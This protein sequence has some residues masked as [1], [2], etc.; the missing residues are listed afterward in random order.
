MKETYKYRLYRNGSYFTNQEDCE[1]ITISSGGFPIEMEEVDFDQFLEKYDSI[2][3][4]KD[5]YVL[6]KQLLEKYKF[7]Y[8]TSEFISLLAAVQDHYLT[9]AE[10]DHTQTIFKDFETEDKDWNSL[11]T[12]IEAYLFRE[13]SEHDFSS[14]NFSSVKRVVNNSGRLIPL[15]NTASITNTFVVNDIYDALCK[16]WNITRE[17]FFEKKK[18]FL[19]GTNKYA[20]SQAATSIKI[21]FTQVLNNLIFPAVIQNKN[22]KNRCIGF[23][24]N[25]AQMS[26]YIKKEDLELNLDQDLSFNL[27]LIAHQNVE[28]LVTRY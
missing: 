3:V 27:D 18:E 15:S 12:M 13:N 28:H 8:T 17:N 11:F 20:F 2:L 26:Y 14:I 16:A 21:E 1:L 10:Q 22:E 24:L 5:I 9:F 25:L 7:T 4:P 6:S 23:I 19:K